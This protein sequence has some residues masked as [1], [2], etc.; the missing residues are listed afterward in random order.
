[1]ITIRTRG[2]TDSEGH[3]DLHLHTNLPESEVDVIV[4]AEPL[5]GGVPGVNHA[6]GWPPDFFARTFGS[7]ADDLVERLPQGL[8]DARDPL[9]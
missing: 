7:L 3:L 8:C 4:V 6:T 5:R 1:M 9:G 2:R